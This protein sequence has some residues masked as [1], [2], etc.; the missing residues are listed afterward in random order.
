M[1][2]RATEDKKE[3]TSACLPWSSSLQITQRNCKEVE[4][5]LDVAVIK[6]KELR[7]ILL[8][9]PPPPSPHLLL[10]AGWAPREARF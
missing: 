4:W 1:T 8:V 5:E 3:G 9:P 10:P 6:S 7:G 2:Q